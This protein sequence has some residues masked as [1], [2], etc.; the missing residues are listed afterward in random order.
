MAISTRTRRTASTLIAAEM[1]APIAPWVAP[2]LPS[3]WEQEAIAVAADQAVE[4]AATSLALSPVIVLVAAFFGVALLAST[5]YF[6]ARITFAIGSKAWARVLQFAQ[7]QQGTIPAP[8]SWIDLRD[9]LR[10]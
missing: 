2:E 5:T 1:A 6:A 3:D 7:A 4:I 8:Q 10:D 9:L